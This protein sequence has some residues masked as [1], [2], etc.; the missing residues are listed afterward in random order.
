MEALNK[1]I[2]CDDIITEPICPDCLATSMKIMVNEYDPPLAE[3]IQNLVFENGET[4]CILCSKKMNLCA[5][6]F[7]KEVY[8]F[9]REK[10]EAVSEE[11]IARF[12]FDLRKELV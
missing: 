8:T 10:N 3:E 9:L 2:E 1:C 7:S 12:D 5:H 4:S 6:C 11:F